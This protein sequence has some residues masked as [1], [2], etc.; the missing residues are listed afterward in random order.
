[1]ASQIGVGPTSYTVVGH[2]VGMAQRMEAAAAPG[3][4]LC[5]ASTARLVEQSA[6]LAPTEWVTVKGIGEPVASRR[7]ERVDPERIVMGRDDGPLMGRDADLTALLDAFSGGQICVVS[8]VGEP[9]VGKSRLIREFAS[10]ATT[11]GV[12]IVI[13]RCDSHTA[14]VPLHA[15]SRMLRAMFGTRG[16][17][18]PTARAHVGAQLDGVAELDSGVGDILFDL[19]S[20][21][22]PEATPPMLNADARRRRLIDVLGKVTRARPVRTIF[23]LEDIHWVDPASEEVI[24]EFAN[25]LSPTNSMLVSTFRPEYHGSLRAM[26]EATITLAPLG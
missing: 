4:I 13:A 21:G 6:I 9:G 7:L 20:V 23:I 17:D 15:F 19:M 10:C 8:V 12:D 2:P 16:L 26:S 24:A 1:V 14:H 25:T 11:A 22:D 3:A 5:T 18:A